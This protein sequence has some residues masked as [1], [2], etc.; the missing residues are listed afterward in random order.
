MVMNIRISDA[1][2]R[3]LEEK[4]KE[5]GVTMTDIVRRALISRLYTGCNRNQTG[6]NQMIMNIRISDAL[7][8]ILEEKAKEEGVTMSVIVRRA[9]ISHLVDK[10]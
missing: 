6:N 8:R 10:L 9:L 2:R 3:I 4:A 7:R 1:L 5:E